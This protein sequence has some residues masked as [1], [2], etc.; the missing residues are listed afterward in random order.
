[1]SLKDEPFYKKEIQDIVAGLQSEDETTAKKAWGR[2]SR[3]QDLLKDHD[4]MEAALTSPHD[5]VKSSYASQVSDP[6]ILNLAA[7]H[8]DFDVRW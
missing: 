4:I 7:D 3:S 2:I 6:E 5:I 1:M 8:P